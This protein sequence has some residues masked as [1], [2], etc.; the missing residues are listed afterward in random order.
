MKTQEVEYY[1]SLAMPE[2]C[3]MQNTPEG[4]RYV[5]E[6]AS[7]PGCSASGATR[8]E[9]GRHLQHAK[10]MWLL[11]RAKQGLEVPL[12]KNANI[13]GQTRT[14][15]AALDISK[16]VA[17]T[18]ANDNAVA[19]KIDEA[20]LATMSLHD[21][22]TLVI[23]EVRR[24]EGERDNGIQRRSKKTTRSRARQTASA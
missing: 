19:L 12:P 23:A 6:V 1:L 7:W 21:V 5:I 20:R 17:L 13:E 18:A 2:F 11:S 14:Y 16:A 4:T 15:F 8:D 24:T 3:S 9:A 10:R 22:V